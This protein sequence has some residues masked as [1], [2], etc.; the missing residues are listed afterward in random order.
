VPLLRAWP[1]TVTCDN[2]AKTQTDID[3]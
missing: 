1:V 2:G 3:Y